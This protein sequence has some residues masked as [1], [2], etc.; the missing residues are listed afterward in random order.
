[1]I[2]KCKNCSGN[3][4]FNPEKMKMHC[5]YCDSMD[6]E[7]VLYSNNMHI[8]DCCGAEIPINQYDSAGR[9][10]ACSQYVIFD[11]RIKGEYEPDKIIPFHFSKNIAKQCIRQEF[12]EHM[13]MPDTF[14]EEV[15]LKSMEGVY[16]PFW[17]Y[18][19]E[20]N[21]D[22]QGTGLKVN[23]RTR[24]NIQYTDNSYYNVVRNFDATFTRMPQDASSGMPNDVM[25]LMEPY[26]Y[27]KMQDFH[28][29]YM[30]GFR[31][32][33][34]YGGAKIFEP[35]AAEKTKSASEQLL[36]DTIRGYTSVTATV[37]KLNM[38]N[39]NSEYALLPVW[40]Y[41][42][43]YRGKIYPFYVN[44]QTGKVI[45]EVPVSKIKKTVYPLTVFA[46]LC[47]GLWMILY[48]IGGIL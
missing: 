1:M 19:F 23:T 38:E 12:G 14:L 5:P 11:E 26:D 16:V 2:F 33:V 21:F 39:T 7:E 40:R 15:T 28:P 46:L 41:L 18:D 27:S 35:R 10:E 42:Y 45:G 6:T 25:D 43:E 8:C 13:Y 22:Y 44:G 48:M 30:S 31:G 37:N 24:G 32:E 17:L 34:Y 3:M 36:K 47:L 9:C 29:K 4:V 20:T